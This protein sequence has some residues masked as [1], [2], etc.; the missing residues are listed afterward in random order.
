M[1][2]FG[3]RRILMASRRA[4]TTVFGVSW[5]AVAQEITSLLKASRMTAAHSQPSPVRI[6]VTSVN[7]FA[8]GTI[9]QKSRLRRSVISGRRLGGAD[10]G[11]DLIRQRAAWIPLILISRA[12]RCRP[13]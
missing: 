2:S 4:F 5:D 7:H 12:T 13:T 9:A 6:W 11:R 1:Q 3:G 8:F 10:R